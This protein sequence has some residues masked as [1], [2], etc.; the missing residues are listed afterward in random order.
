MAL[1]AGQQLALSQ[2]E[3]ICR[4]SE[5]EVMIAD[6]VEPTED[7]PSLKLRISLATRH[8]ERTEDG[9]PL[10]KR[11]PLWLYIPSKFP[12]DYPSVYAVHT[13]FA[14]LVRC[15]PS[16]AAALTQGDKVAS[17]RRSNNKHQSRTL[18]DGVDAGLSCNA[19]IRLRR[20][21]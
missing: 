19:A 11:E 14:G 5:H 17:G 3:D 20:T 4:Y 13:R 15:K 16:V 10:R 1:T 21:Q 9:L 7:Q 6:I 8:H 12:R 18:F 2:L